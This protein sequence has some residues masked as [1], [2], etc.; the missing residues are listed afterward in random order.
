MRIV[1]A[2]AI[3]LSSLGAVLGLISVTAE[4]LATRRTQAEAIAATYPPPPP[5]M[6]LIPAGSFLMGSDDPLADPDERPRRSVYLPAFYIDRNEVTNAAYARYDPGHAFPPERAEYPVTGRSLAQARAY[7]EWAGKRLPTRAEWE[8]AARGTDGRLYPWGN[9][10]EAG[11]ANI[12]R[13][14]AL[15]AVGTYPQGASPYGVEDMTGN[16]WEWVDE[17]FHD[18]TAFGTQGK[19]REIIKGGGFSYSPY[20]GRVSYNGFE[21]IGS[22]CN[23]IGFRCVLDAVPVAK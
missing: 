7:A 2:T 14:D 9:T 21:A 8:K 3:I 13:G 20:Q 22:T 5:D 1:P 19:T 4:G 18:R 23:D 17:P 6:I 11:R 10:Y 12:G 16:A 15:A